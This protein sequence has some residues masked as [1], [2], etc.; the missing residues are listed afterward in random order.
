MSAV[1][2][3]VQHEMTSLRNKRV[4]DLTVPEYTQC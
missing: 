2:V 3:Y 1:N 4:M